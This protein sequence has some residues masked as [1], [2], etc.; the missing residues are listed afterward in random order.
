MKNPDK[1]IVSSSPHIYGRESTEKIMWTVTAALVPAGIAGIFFFGFGVLR[2]I[3]TAIIAAVLTEI[4]AQKLRHRP[5]T[6]SDGSAV[7]AGLLLAYNLPPNFPLWMTALGAV[8]AIGLGKHVFGGLGHNIF[9]PALIGRVFL[10]ASFP[11][12]M[13]KFAQA[14]NVDA[15]AMPTPLAIAKTQGIAA[16]KL[17]MSSVDF[18]RDLFIGSRGGCLGEVCIIALLAGAAYL[19]YKG[20]IS[21]QTPL[22]F[23]AT[24]LLMG[25][26]FGGQGFFKGDVVFYLLSGGLVLGA[27]FMATDYVT[28][29]LTKN[30]QLIFGAGCGLITAVIR[31]WGGYPEGVS[32]AI[33]IMN[34]FTPLIDNFTKTKRFGAKTINA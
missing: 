22:S 17:N 24:C 18:Y 21:W 20:Y 32:Y 34:A 16:L 30:G 1:L 26:I 33:L 23:I 8:V 27:F 13:T 6:I 10:L 12:A 19:L 9:N 25:W 4:V 29:P 15:V 14:F 3:I 28:S 2:V 5:I 11:R 31:I 7:L